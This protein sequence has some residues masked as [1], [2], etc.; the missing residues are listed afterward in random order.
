MHEV[1]V[2]HL[3]KVE[4]LPKV[5]PSVKFLKSIDENLEICAERLSKI[6]KKQFLAVKLSEIKVKRIK[7][8]LRKLKLRFSR[9][10]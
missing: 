1:I 9:I 4:T 3:K 7:Q 10:S 6:S 5:K 8:A 2:P